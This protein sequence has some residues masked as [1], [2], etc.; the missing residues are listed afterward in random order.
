MLS[1]IL[2]FAPIINFIG[3]TLKLGGLNVQIVEVV[4]ILDVF[5]VI[6]QRDRDRNFGRFLCLFGRS[7]RLLFRNPEILFF[8]EP[9]SFRLLLL[10][11]FLVF[12]MG[13]LGGKFVLFQ[14]R[15]FPVV[16]R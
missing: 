16:G 5:V 8:L 10:Q 11:V 7:G 3:G 12:T 2:R 9:V 4:K 13:R 15:P 6:V 14:N 1:R